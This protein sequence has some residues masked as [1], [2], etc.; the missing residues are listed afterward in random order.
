MVAESKK[1]N[2]EITKLT[3]TQRKNS[4]KFVVFVFKKM[5]T[6]ASVF[7]VQKNVGQCCSATMLLTTSAERVKPK[8]AVMWTMEPLTWALRGSE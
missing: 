7:C 8:T 4:C 5:S 1:T 2:T 6:F 3:E